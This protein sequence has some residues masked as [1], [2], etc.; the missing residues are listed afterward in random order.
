VLNT[1]SIIN[2]MSK[3]LSINGIFPIPIA[4][5]EIDLPDIAKINWVQGEEFLQS[6]DDLHT[7]DYMQNTVTQI[8]DSA[9]AFAENVGWRKEKYFITQMWANKYSPN[10]E[11]KKGGNIH[12]HFHSN[13]LLSGVLYFDENSPTR[14]F[15]HDKTRQ[16]IKTSMAENT[17]FT[18]EIFTVNAKPGR[19]LIFPS[20][21]VHDSEPSDKERITIAFNI[22]PESLGVK[23]DYNFIDLSKT[24]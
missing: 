10:T 4:T 15:N 14:I 16:I 21:L 23:M 9:C 6:E 1:Y 8:L 13:S 11:E 19:L 2:S 18:S 20:Y 12:A 17:P 7:K 22:M 24:Q 5:T 3:Q